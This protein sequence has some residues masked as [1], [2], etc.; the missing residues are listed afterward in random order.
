MNDDEIFCLKIQL[1]VGLIQP[2]QIQRCLNKRFL[3]NYTDQLLL[4]MSFIRRELDLKKFIYNLV[5]NSLNREQIAL[6]IFK[7]YF[8]KKMPR[9]LDENLDI[10]IENLKFIADYLVN[11][12]E[13][14]NE[15]FLSSYITA[16]DDQIT[17]ASFGNIGMWPKEAYSELYRYLQNWIQ[18]IVE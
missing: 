11:F 18:S 16:F 5:D 8:Y 14:R 12:N 1:R 17:E 13:L 4:E 9:E 6:K 7:K 3:K 2:K 15:P 10:H